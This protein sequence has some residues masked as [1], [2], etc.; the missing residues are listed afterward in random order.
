MTGYNPGLLMPITS[1]RVMRSAIAFGIHFRPA[2]GVDCGRVAELLSRAVGG[3][4][5]PFDGFLIL[6]P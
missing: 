6:F 1:Y 5:N 2:P 3:G 4:I